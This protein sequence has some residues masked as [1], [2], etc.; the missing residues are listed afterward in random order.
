MKL[1]PKNKK[2]K[3]QIKGKKYTHELLVLTD[4]ETS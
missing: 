1:F 2:L 3:E 4:T